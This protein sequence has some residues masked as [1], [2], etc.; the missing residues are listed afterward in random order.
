MA[1]I[2]RQI[3]NALDEKPEFDKQKAKF[4][5][6][7]KDGDIIGIFREVGMNPQTNL[8][9]GTITL[10]SG[11]SAKVGDTSYTIQ[12][13]IEFGDYKIS[14]LRSLEEINGKKTTWVK[15]K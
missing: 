3:Q 11:Y 12:G 4:A 14:D 5:Q 1:L 9:D 13:S 7:Q 10:N 8:K 2:I 6:M 15:V